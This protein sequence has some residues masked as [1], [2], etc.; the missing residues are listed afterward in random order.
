[1]Q[2]V[3]ARLPKMSDEQ[4][5]AESIRLQRS[6]SK[7]HQNLVKT[8]RLELARR[9]AVC[10]DAVQADDPAAWQTYAPAMLRA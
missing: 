10:V 9:T 2:S 6:A 1:M 5:L 8:Y 3:R 7:E 4:L